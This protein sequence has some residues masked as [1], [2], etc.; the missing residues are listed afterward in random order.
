[1][2]SAESLQTGGVRILRW[3]PKKKGGHI[4]HLLSTSCVVT[5]SASGCQL[6]HTKHVTLRLGVLHLV[7]LDDI[8]WVS[9]AGETSEPLLAC[10]RPS[11]DDLW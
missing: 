6:R 9:V 4:K 7:S 2:R 8:I 3:L 5:T 1:M 10:E 11:V